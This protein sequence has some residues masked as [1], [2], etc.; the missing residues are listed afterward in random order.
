MKKILIYALVVAFGFA[1]VN[2]TTSYDAFGNPQQTVS[3]GGAVAGAAAAGVLGY[4]IANNNN[5][6]NDRFVNQR[7]YNQRLINRRAVILRNQRINK[8]RRVG[9]KRR[10]IHRRGNFCHY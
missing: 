6:N 5:R 3:P 7:I 10:A 1:S 8:F 4:A 2:C 9:L